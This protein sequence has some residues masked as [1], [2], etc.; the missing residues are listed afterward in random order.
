MTVAHPGSR[1]QIAISGRYAGRTSAR[2]VVCPLRRKCSFIRNDRL[3]DFGQLL[4]LVMREFLQA[5]KGILLVQVGALH[6]DAFGPFNQL[7]I[8]Q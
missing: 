8:C 3:G 4:I 1:K 7:V 5:A 2:R 6:Q